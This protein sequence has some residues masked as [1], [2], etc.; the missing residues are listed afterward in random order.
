MR[1]GP[2]RLKAASGVNVKTLS[3]DQLLDL[4]SAVDARLGQ[5]RSVDAQGEV[6]V[7]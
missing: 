5:Y 3:V 7:W 1:R 6:G 2:G 4:K